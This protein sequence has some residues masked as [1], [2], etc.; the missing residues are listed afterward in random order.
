MYINIPVQGILAIHMLHLN[1]SHLAR[2][3]HIYPQG[4]RNTY[5][6]LL[7]LYPE[8]IYFTELNVVAGLGIFVKWL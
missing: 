3:H 1:S 6:A 8:Q 4:P 7:G 5:S 2:L